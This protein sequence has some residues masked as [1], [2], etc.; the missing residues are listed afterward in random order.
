MSS[1]AGISPMSPD[2][3]N[4]DPADAYSVTELS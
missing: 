4:I 2:L 1:G 3:V